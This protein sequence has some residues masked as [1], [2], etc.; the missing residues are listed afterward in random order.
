MRLSAPVSGLVANR[1]SMNIAG[2]P[3]TSRVDWVRLGKEGGANTLGLPNTARATRVVR[4]W[5]VRG[6]HSPPVTRPLL[7]YI[8]HTKLRPWSWRSCERKPARVYATVTIA[9]LRPT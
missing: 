2:K 6:E 3:F 5:S 8:A 7:A 9:L 4:A 1:P